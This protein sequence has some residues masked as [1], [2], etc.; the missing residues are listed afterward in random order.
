MCTPPTP[1]LSA[2]EGL[3]LLGMTCVVY[4]SSFIKS[5]FESFPVALLKWPEHPGKGRVVAVE[6]SPPVESQNCFL[7]LVKEHLRLARTSLQRLCNHL[8]TLGLSG[9]FC[10]GHRG[11]FSAGGVHAQRCS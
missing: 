9:S 3:L 7:P 5:G 10:L 2:L 11:G 1:A 4:Y 8:S 6:C